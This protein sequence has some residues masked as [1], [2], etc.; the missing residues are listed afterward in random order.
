MRLFNISLKVDWLYSPFSNNLIFSQRVDKCLSGRN[1][2]TYHPDV[3]VTQL[4][5]CNVPPHVNNRTYFITSHIK[6]VKSSIRKKSACDCSCW[7]INCTMY[8]N[9]HRLL[10]YNLIYQRMQRKM[11]LLYFSIL[12][13]L[14]LSNTEK[15]KILYFTLLTVRISNVVSVQSLIII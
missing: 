7:N 6:H 12:S 8:Y 5:W 1:I 3:F 14:F 2:L 15:L 10:L 13:E 4:F 9:H 11:A